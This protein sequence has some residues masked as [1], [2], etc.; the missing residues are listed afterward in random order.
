MADC[1]GLLL[2]AGAGRRFGGPKA[3][4]ELGGEPLVRRAL[5]ALEP[6]SPVYVVT[7]AA[8]GEVTAL[9]PAAV[10]P[11][12]APEWAAGMGESLRAG[13]SALSSVEAGAVL[14]HLVDLPDVTDAVVRRLTAL[15]APDVVA[16][17]T[18][19]GVPGH[20]VLLGRDHWAGIADAVSGDA[21]ARHWLS[22]RN[23][24]HLVECGDLGGGRDVDRPEDLPPP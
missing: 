18:Y 4:V 8:A 1:A 13:L 7:G 2:A 20:P 21:G 24:L 22:T 17:A 5:R 6:C 9:L 10:F 14:V 16:R 19:A 15:A 11:V 12:H 3:L 23:D